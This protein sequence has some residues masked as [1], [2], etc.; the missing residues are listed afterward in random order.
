MADV[1]SFFCKI[2]TSKLITKKKK[3]QKNRY[4][5]KTPFF[6]NLKKIHSDSPK[7]YAIFRYITKVRTRKLR[8]I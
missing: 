8:E 5:E 6:K 1:V 7:Y 3:I 2:F 4:F